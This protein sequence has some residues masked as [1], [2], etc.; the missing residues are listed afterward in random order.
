MKISE[1]YESTLLWSTPNNRRKV[2][3]WAKAISEYLKEEGFPAHRPCIDEIVVA[4]E[5]GTHPH[6]RIVVNTDGQ[7]SVWH[8]G[9]TTK[10]FEV[11][12]YDP[13][14]FEIIKEFVSRYKY[15]LIISR[16]DWVRGRGPVAEDTWQ[17]MAASSEAL[18]ALAS[19][20]EDDGFYIKSLVPWRTITGSKGHYLS[21][22]MSPEESRRAEFFRLVV[23]LPDDSLKA[24]IYRL[25]PAAQHLYGEM[26]NM[27]FDLAEPGSFRKIAARMRE[28]AGY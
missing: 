9:P 17:T 22:Y 3:A 24:R 16:D 21:V 2:N 7:I 25:G 20:L 10:P 14:S 19:Y 4:K 18:A 8:V 15:D 27:L 26:S 11:S 13:D 28:L 12:I 5:Y 1:L 23:S 6:T